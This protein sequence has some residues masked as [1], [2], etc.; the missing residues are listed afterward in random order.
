LGPT[1]DWTIRLAIFGSAFAVALL[2][3]VW[4]IQSMRSRILRMARG[5]DPPGAKP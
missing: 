2:L 4:S 3:S 5:A 1:A